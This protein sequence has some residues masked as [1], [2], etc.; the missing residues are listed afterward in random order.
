MISIIVAMDMNQGIGMNNSIP[1]K[2]SKDMMFFKETTTD[3][4]CIM[5]RK[6]HESIGR[7]LPNR[8]N[9]VL[10][11]DKDYESN[12]AFIFNDIDKLK[13]FCTYHSNV[14]IIGG[15][16]LYREFLSEDLVDRLYVTHINEYFMTDTLFPVFKHLFNKCDII[17]KDTE[18]GLDFT[19]SVYTK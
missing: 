4:V 10:T 14:F 1:W 17:K 11:R 5:G 12:G 15:S 6:T 3:S 16:E 18:N 19:I 9:V 13:A 7:L 8:M 2:L